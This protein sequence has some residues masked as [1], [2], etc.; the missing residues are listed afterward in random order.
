MITPLQCTC[1]IQNAVQQDILKRA[2]EAELVMKVNEVG[3]DISYCIEHPHTES[4]IPFVCG[5]GPRKASSLLKVH[6]CTCTSFIFGNYINV[7]YC[8]Q[9]IRQ[10]SIQI[11]NRSQ[12][13]TQCSIGPQV[14]INCAGFIKVIMGSYILRY[15]ICFM[16]TITYNVYPKFSLF[17]VFEN[18]FSLHALNFR[19]LATCLE[20]KT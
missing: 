18:K 10:E 2:L 1:I 8:F 4:L 6:T 14:F 5:F 11:L 9:T 20:I 13:V 12:L 15:C 19:I 17:K 3:V 16:C 7:S